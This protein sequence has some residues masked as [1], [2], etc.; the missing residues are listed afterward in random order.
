MSRREYAIYV[1]LLVFLSVVSAPAQDERITAAWDSVLQ[2]SSGTLPASPPS[3]P[4]PG[5]DF[6]KHFFFESRTD[7]WRYSTSFTGLPTA[8]N[9]ISAPFTGDFN[10]NGIPY[11][12]AF[13]P[14]AN[15]VYAFVDWGTRGWLSDRVNTHFSYRYAQDVTPVSTAAPAANL[16]ETFPGNRNFELTQATVEIDGKST[17][18]LWAGTSLTLGRQYVYGAELA[19]LDGASF[20][21]NRERFSVTVFG[22][23]RFSNFSDPVQRG[24]GGA[25][26]VFRLSKDASIEYDGLWYIRGSNSVAFRKRLATNW[27]VSSYFRAYGGSPVDLSMQALYTPRDGRTTLRFGFFQK[28][29]DRDYYYDYTYLAASRDP[30]T[31][32]SRLYVGPISPYS[33]FTADLHRTVGGRLR[34]GGSLWIRRLNDSSAQGQFD[35]SFQDYRVHAQLF[36]LRRTET[37]L[38]YHQRNSDRLAP[39]NTTSFDDIR[40][41]GETRVQDV[42]AEMRRSFYE[43]RVGVSGGVYYRRIQFQDAFYDRIHAHQSGF[44]AWA[45]IRLDPRTRL[46]CDYN[47]DNDFFLYRPSIANS[48]ILRLGLS[49]KY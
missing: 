18:G 48:R 1:F 20:N 28:L 27:L 11:P 26:I 6:L 43:R 46:Y 16:I 12:L 10:P 7:Y 34:F 47:L 32:L 2:N 36:G 5:A 4:N 24:L 39:S 30:Y 8:T 25:N 37:M 23:R 19:A 38:E 3:K 21:I 42:T 40:A 45:W 41:S 33:Q 29:T 31:L 35:T 9:V 22:G 49:W 17:D 15:R 44:L 14:D 13:Q